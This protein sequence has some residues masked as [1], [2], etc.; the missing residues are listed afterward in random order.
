MILTLEKN[1]IKRKIVYGVIQSAS[2]ILKYIITHYHSRYSTIF[3]PNLRVQHIIKYIVL[4]RVRIWVIWRE[5][6]CNAFFF[7]ILYTY[8]PAAIETALFRSR[9]RNDR[10]TCPEQSSAVCKNCITTTTTII[11]IIILKWYNTSCVI[12]I[13]EFF[14]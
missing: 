5:L 4:M 11:I 14:T 6:S 12:C 2:P 8:C 1:L 9:R 13:R 10:N 7:F 3:K